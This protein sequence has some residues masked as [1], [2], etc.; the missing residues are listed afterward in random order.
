MPRFLFELYFVTLTFINFV[1]T[2]GPIALTIPGP[3]LSPD[4][5]DADSYRPAYRDQCAPIRTELAA[6]PRIT[7]SNVRGYVLR[8]R[9]EIANIEVERESGPGQR[10]S[11][12]CRLDPRNIPPGA[13]PPRRRD[14]A[15]T[16]YFCRQPPGTGT[17]DQL[18]LRVIRSSGQSRWRI[19]FCARRK[20]CRSL[21]KREVKRD[22]DSINLIKL[23]E[24]KK[25]MR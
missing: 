24:R 25:G 14:A 10:L 9:S 16:R 7:L 8:L 18:I 12:D 21:C 15:V 2:T 3:I 22:Y 4:C 23:I 11:V 20:W 6:I 5:K 1:L 13:G 19:E 17:P